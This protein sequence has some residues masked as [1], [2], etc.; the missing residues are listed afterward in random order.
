M[1]DENKISNKEQRQW[2]D[3]PLIQSDTNYNIN[4]NELKNIESLKDGDSVNIRARV[5]NKRGKGNCCFL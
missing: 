2:G 4:F 5:H 3:I 1:Q